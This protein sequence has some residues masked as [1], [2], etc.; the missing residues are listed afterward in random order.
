M[1]SRQ[2]ARPAV[3]LGAVAVAMV[4]AGLPFLNKTVWQREQNVAA[5]RD[6]ALDAKDDARSARLSIK[7]D[8]K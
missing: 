1:A 6:A 8:I 2:S 4:I 3:V 5:M 7:Q